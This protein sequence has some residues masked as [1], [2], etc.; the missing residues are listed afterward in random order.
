PDASPPRHP[1]VPARRS[2][3]LPPQE[4]G[5]TLRTYDLRQGIKQL[6]TLKSGQTPNIDKLM[7]TV[8]WTEASQVGLEDHFLTHVVGNVHA[9]EDGEYTCRLTSDDGS[10]LSIGAEVVVDNDG[11]H[12]EE[13]VEGTVTLTAGAHPLFVEFFEDAYGQVLRLEWMPPGADE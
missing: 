9:P 7:P 6:C 8:D 12:G 13:S 4:P 3:A 5:V 2:S 1:A 10:R 11:L